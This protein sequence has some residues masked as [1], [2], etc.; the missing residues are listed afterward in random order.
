MTPPLFLSYL[1]MCVYIYVSVKSQISW[2][3]YVM[4]WLEKKNPEVLVYTIY[5]VL[6]D[7]KD[8]QRPDEITSPDMKKCILVQI[9]QIY[10]SNI[11]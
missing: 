7:A 5:I 11:W 3:Y 6:G 9:L 1:R 2:G 4:T 8:Q 10:G